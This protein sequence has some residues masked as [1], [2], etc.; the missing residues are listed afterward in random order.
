MNNPIQWLLGEKSLELGKDWPQVPQV[1]IPK[2]LDIDYEDMETTIQVHKEIE[3]DMFDEEHDCHKGPEDSCEVCDTE[4]TLCGQPHNNGDNSP[5]GC[6]GE[7][8]AIKLG[9]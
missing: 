8:M 4:E 1:E 5:E 2:Q 6:G 7:C 3:K 9:I